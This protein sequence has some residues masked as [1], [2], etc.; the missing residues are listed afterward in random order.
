MIRTILVCFLMLGLT[1]EAMAKGCCKIKVR[2]DPKPPD[3]KDLGGT[4]ERTVRDMGNA[5]KEHPVLPF[6]ALGKQ[7]VKSSAHLYQKNIDTVRA[8]GRFSACLYSM[9]A[10]EIHRDQEIKREERARERR[11][12]EYRDGQLS[13]YQRS[14]N[15]RYIALL[16]Q[17][18]DE[19]L[20]SI[21]N[22]DELLTLVKTHTET[23]AAFN[24]TIDAEIQLR[25]DLAAIGET[26]EM[27]TSVMDSAIA[28][29]QAHCQTD[30]PMALSVLT[31]RILEASAAT[32]RE[33]Q[34]LALEA[35]RA[36]D[37]QTIEQLKRLKT[38][39]TDEHFREL[40]SLTIQ[41]QTRASRILFLE[42]EL[43]KMGA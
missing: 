15:E 38:L 6:V 32:K 28:E 39:E 14:E 43:K 2:W 4:I 7:S 11:I 12:N 9:C 25:K 19:T 23:I 34:E 21:T 24:K 36:M 33:V 13:A 10:S 22:T 31:S 40:E 18:L 16:K 37:N 42:S 41:R 3:F 8:I 5:V 35:L 26:V 29:Y 30:A 27:Q 17:E 1:P 20:S